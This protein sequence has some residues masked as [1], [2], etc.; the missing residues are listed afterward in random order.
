M[1]AGYSHQ[2]TKE[3][4]IDNSRLWFYVLLGTA[5]ASN[6][7][8]YC[9]APLVGV[10]TIAGSTVSRRKAI[11]VV[12][13][14]WCF[15]QFLG[16]TVRD[17]PYTPSTFAWGIVMGVGAILAV[18]L[19]TVKLSSVRKQPGG[20]YIWFLASLLLGYGIYE[21]ILWISSFALGGTEN[22]TAS[23]LWDVLAGNAVWA[24]VLGLVHY[25]LVQ[26]WRDRV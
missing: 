13:C 15:N 24:I 1:T 3:Q 20:S 22:F 18:L 8:Y 5:T 25:L 21:L 19:S 17:Y 16:F 2:L 7:V 9:T 11:A 10:G 12:L 14:M 23:I 6:L 26:R 4:A